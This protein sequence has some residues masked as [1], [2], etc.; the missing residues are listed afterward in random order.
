[1]VVVYFKKRKRYREA[2]IRVMYIQAKGHQGPLAPSAAKR[3]A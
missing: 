1:M 2:Q 3:Q